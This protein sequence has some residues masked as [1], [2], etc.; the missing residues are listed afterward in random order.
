MQEQSNI[1]DKSSPHIY[2]ATGVYML[3]KMIKPLA[4]LVFGLILIV[5]G[6]IL[7]F[8]ESNINSFALICIGVLL[9]LAGF[10]ILWMWLKM[11]KSVKK[12]Y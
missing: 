3:L 6:I 4:L 7:S 10:G 5:V 8:S 9:S 2:K 12:F 1:V 11:H